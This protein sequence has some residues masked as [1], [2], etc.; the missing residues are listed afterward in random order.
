MTRRPLALVAALTLLATLTAPP[1]ALQ[2]LQA[3]Q[4]L[5]AARAQDPARGSFDPAADRDLPPPV[6][7]AAREGARYVRAIVFGDWGSRGPGQRLVAQAM[8]ERARREPVDLLI[9]TGDNFY[10]RGVQSVDDPQ[11]AAKFEGIYGD[12]ALQV[13]VFPALGNHDYM[14]RVEAQVEY[15]R[16]NP[17]WRLPAR[18]HAFTWPP[19]AQAPLVEVFIA[20]TQAM[21]LRGGDADQRAWLAAALERST[22]RWKVVVGHHPIYSNGRHGGSGSLRERLEPLLIEHRVDLY[23]AGH[24]HHLEMLRPVSG[25][26]H[27]VS[28]GG[29]GPEMAYRSEWVDETSYYAATGGGFVALR[30]GDDDLVLE[31]VRTDGR[32][33]FA[34]TLIKG[35]SGPY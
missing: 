4:A 28:G 18:Y 23:M 19:E 25:V 27:L 33:Q 10:P 21:L 2:A 16:V 9:T 7:P 1:E 11:W 14:G 3:L 6:I 26:H 35:P 22:A 8:A 12:P 30:A 20:D 31:F 24:D 34:H 17:R 5:P 29:G 15:S 32:T 13:P